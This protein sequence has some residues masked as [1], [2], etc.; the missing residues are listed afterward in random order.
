MPDI[1]RQCIKLPVFNAGIRYA[2][3]FREQQIC[4]LRHGVYFTSLETACFNA[5]QIMFAIASNE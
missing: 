1:F 5:V 2:L 3:C 4:I